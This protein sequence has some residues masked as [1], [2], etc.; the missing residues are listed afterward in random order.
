VARPPPLPPYNLTL[1]HKF[2]PQH[3]YYTD[4]SFKPPKLTPTNTWRRERAGYGIYNSIK[5]IQI[6]ARLLRLQNILRAELMA[7]H[8]TI[9]LI[10]YQYS[11]EPAHI[12]TNS[13][14]SLYL[15]KTQ[16]T[17]PTLHNNHP[18][19]TILASLAHMLQTR[20]HPL[21]LHKVRAHINIPGNEFADKLTKDGTKLPHR[22][23]HHEYEYAHPTPYYLHKNTWPFM[24]NTPYKGPIRHLDPYL[25]KYYKHHN[26]QILANSFPNITK[27]TT[28]T[29]IDLPTSTNFWSHPAVTDSQKTCLLKFRYNQYMGNAR[30]QLFFGPNRFPSI[31]CPICPS[32]EPTHGSMSFLLATINTFMPLESNDI[33]KQSGKFA[34]S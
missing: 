3:S 22:N 31:T 5:N 17:H 25:Q 14:T 4:G 32:L 23:P 26:F 6:S 34:N 16:L 1:P 2:L 18:D 24:D 30:K 10:N 28:D 33:I 7:L 15:I 8:H 11:N 20:T 13:L 21:S 29:N 9:Q 27:W 12:F 19:K